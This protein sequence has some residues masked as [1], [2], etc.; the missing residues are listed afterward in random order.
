MIKQIL[1]LLIAQLTAVGSYMPGFDDFLT[2]LSVFSMV[3]FLILFQISVESCF[4][5]GSEEKYRCS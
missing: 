2:H 1:C 3:Y 5:V 4:V